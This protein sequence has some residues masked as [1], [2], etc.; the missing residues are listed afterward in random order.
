MFESL[1]LI[2]SLDY[3]VSEQEGVKSISHISTFHKFY[4]DIKTE[5][6]TLEGRIRVFNFGLMVRGLSQR[7]NFP[8]APAATRDSWR[9]IN[10][11]K[12]I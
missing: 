8:V 9:S 11:E 1:M 6:N 3:F 12:D 5:P 4:L 10:E 2:F 7:P